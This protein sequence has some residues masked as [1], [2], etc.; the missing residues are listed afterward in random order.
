MGLDQLFPGSQVNGGILIAMVLAVMVYVIFS[1]TTLGYQLKACG[2][3]RYAARY[4]GIRTSA[5]LCC[6]WR[7]P[8]PWPVRR[9]RCIT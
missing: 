2:A 6:P 3:N 9:G 8:A 4:A 5:I 1:R 7:L